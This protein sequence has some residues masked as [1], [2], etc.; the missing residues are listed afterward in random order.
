MAPSS[1]FLL[2]DQSGRSAKPAYVLIAL[3]SENDLCVFGL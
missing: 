3:K 2:R 1:E